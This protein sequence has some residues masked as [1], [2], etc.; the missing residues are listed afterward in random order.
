VSNLLDQ[1]VHFIAEK[2]VLVHYTI[3]TL[4]VPART[5]SDA[6]WFAYLWYSNGE[7]SC[8]FAPELPAQQ[9]H[10]APDNDTSGS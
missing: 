5:A 10:L 9:D 4:I 3:Q 2:D 7:R 1:E 6:A 8:A